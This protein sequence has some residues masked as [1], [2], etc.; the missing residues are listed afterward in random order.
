MF[1]PEEVLQ[2]RRKEIARCEEKLRSTIRQQL[3]R[4][5]LQ[6]RR[7]TEA[8]RLLGPEQTLRRGYSITEDETGKVI[9]SVDAVSPNQKL[10][11]I[12]A[13]GTIWSTTE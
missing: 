2:R 12:L 3:E 8:V 4:E 11:T 10:K 7:L 6:I 13:D 9:H 1:K 5:R